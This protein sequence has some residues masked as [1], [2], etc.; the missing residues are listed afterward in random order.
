MVY[1][2]KVVNI[3]IV[4][5]G[6]LPEGLAFLDSVECPWYIFRFDDGSGCA[7]HGRAA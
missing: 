2:G 7:G 3:Y 6:Y 5:F 1:L 4:N